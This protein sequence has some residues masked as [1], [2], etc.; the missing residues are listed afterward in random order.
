MENPFA[1][2]LARRGYVAAT[3]EY[4]LSNEAKHP[5]QIHDLKAAIRWLRANAARYHVDR[6]HRCDRSIGRRHLVALLGRRMNCQTSKER[7]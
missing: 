5:A 6:T 7:R 1:I 2:E 3:I 4:R